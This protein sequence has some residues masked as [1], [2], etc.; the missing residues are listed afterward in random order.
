[1]FGKW[2]N[3]QRKSAK[4]ERNIEHFEILRFDN[5]FNDWNQDDQV[6][7]YSDAKDLK[8]KKLKVEKKEN[9][10]KWVKMREKG[11]ALIP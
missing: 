2:E 10:G 6:T 1:M 4:E 7:K 3:L 9:E 8:E 5:D 11:F